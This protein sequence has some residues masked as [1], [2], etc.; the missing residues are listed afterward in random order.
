MSE[1]PKTSEEHSSLCR[2]LNNLFPERWE[3]KEKAER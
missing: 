2:V 1:K 3:K